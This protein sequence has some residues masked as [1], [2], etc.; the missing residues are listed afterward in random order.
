MKLKSKGETLGIKWQQ[1]FQKRHQSYTVCKYTLNGKPVLVYIQKGYDIPSRLTVDSS[2][3]YGSQSEIVFFVY[4]DKSQKPYQHRFIDGMS[5][6]WL[7]D[8]FGGL[9]IDSSTFIGDYLHDV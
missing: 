2:L 5:A 6:E 1:E 3:Q 7:K 9:D 8:F 4:H